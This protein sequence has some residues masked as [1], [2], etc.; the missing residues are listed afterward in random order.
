[1]QSHVTFENTHVDRAGAAGRAL[2][3][4]SGRE[5]SSF[6]FTYYFAYSHRQTGC[7]ASKGEGN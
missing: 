2:L 5:Y 1:M 7:C 3:S 4:P 6:Y